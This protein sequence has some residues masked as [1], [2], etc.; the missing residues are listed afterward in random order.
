[1]ARI[2]IP[3]SKINTMQMQAQKNNAFYES[4][5]N[6]S[7]EEVLQITQRSVDDHLGSTE[8]GHSCVLCHN[9]AVGSDLFDLKE[10]GV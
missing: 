2:Q 4:M 10:D 7:N 5:I 3:Q 6:L 9:I 8:E 1:M